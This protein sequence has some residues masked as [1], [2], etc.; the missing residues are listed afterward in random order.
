MTLLFE[1]GRSLWWS[2]AWIAG[3]IATPGMWHAGGRRRCR[4]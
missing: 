1:P 4:G 3:M 2:W